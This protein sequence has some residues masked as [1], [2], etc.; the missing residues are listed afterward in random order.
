MMG[1][2]L[3]QKWEVGAKHAL[4]HRDGFWYHKLERFPGAYFDSAGYVLF[5]TEE[6]YKSSPHLSIGKT[7][8]VIPGCIR[9]IPGYKKVD[10]EPLFQIYSSRKFTLWRRF[11]AFLAKLVGRG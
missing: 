7:V 4:F 8:Y 9:F 6:E 2:I 1:N 3:N 10:E 11:K 5:N